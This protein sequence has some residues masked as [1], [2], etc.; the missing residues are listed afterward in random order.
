MNE[1]NTVSEDYS[2]LHAELWS[3]SFVDSQNRTEAFREV[4]KRVPPHNSIPDTKLGM[5]MNVVYQLITAAASKDLRKINRDAFA[6]EMGGYDV[7]LIGPTTFFN[8]H[9]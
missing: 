4:L 1:M 8:H 3:Q 7:S 5:Q 9:Y 6:I 2:S